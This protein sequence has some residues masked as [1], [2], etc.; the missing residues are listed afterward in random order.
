MNAFV[1]YFSKFDSAAQTCKIPWTIASN[2]ASIYDVDPV[3]S[4]ER[5]RALK[6]SRLE[7]FR[8]LKRYDPK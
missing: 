6:L 8:A 4:L 2:I 5:F 7:S 1:V 3:A